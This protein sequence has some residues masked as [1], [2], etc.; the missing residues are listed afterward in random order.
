MTG[1]PDQ[2]TAIVVEHRAYERG[3]A[4]V[5][6]LALEHGSDRTAIGTAEFQTT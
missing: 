6:D 2:M 1:L 3:V 4:V 5:C